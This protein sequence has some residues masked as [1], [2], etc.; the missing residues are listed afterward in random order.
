MKT[1]ISL[2]IILFSTF[3]YAQSIDVLV[4]LSPAGSF[5]AITKSVKGEASV[6]GGK[7]SA[8]NVQ[9]DLRT[10]S[11]GVDLRDKHLKDRLQVDK[12]PI[13][14]LVTA[15]G[16]SGKGTATLEIKGSKQNVSGT[17]AVEGKT[18]RAEFKMKMTDLGINDARYM[19]VGAKD[20]VTVTIELPVRN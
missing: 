14:K 20:E 15:E 6:Q 11:T 13:A 8:N 10:L 1:L 18:L 17:Y 5:H 19:G 7:V 16:Q 12:F 2:F 9:V 3:T 4:K